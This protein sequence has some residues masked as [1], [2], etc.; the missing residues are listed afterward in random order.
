MIAPPL[1]VFK[2]DWLTVQIT[3]PRAMNPEG[4]RAVLA[5]LAKTGSPAGRTAPEDAPPLALPTLRQFAAVQPR[6]RAAPARLAPS[7]Q[8]PATREWD[9]AL[10][11]TQPEL[12]ACAETAIAM[13]RFNRP[14]L[15][16]VLSQAGVS[17]HGLADRPDLVPVI[18]AEL[19]RGCGNAE[20][21]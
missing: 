8:A 12:L 21:R 20:A 10:P 7:G 5:L 3:D 6:K 1:V 9:G 17:L 2:S 18:W 14:R 19:T 13:G 16:Q 4:V 15:W 11:V